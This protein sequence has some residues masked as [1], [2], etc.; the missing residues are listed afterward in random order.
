MAIGSLGIEHGTMVYISPD[1]DVLP[2][3][4]SSFELTPECRHSV[5]G[6]CLHCVS[7]LFGK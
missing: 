2:E 4:A 6:R 5:K 7:L 3:T 1:E